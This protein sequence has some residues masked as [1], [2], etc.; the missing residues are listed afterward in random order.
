MDRKGPSV[1]SE[2]FK[3]IIADSKDAQVKTF[4]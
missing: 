4:T 2:P 3:N 1:D